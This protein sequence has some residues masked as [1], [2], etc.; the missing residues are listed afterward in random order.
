MTTENRDKTKKKTWQRRIEKA[1][2]AHRP[3][4]KDWSIGG[5]ATFKSKE[6]ETFISNK[7]S[8][9]VINIKSID[10]ITPS[11]NSNIIYRI[12]TKHLSVTNFIT[13]FEMNK[14]PLII[15]KIPKY[16]HWKAIKNWNLQSL[17]SHYK[18]CLFKV[19]EDDD[20]YKLK[21]KLKYFLKYLRHN[22]DDSP[23]YIFDSNYDNNSISK[24]LLDDY[25]V[26]SYFPDDLFSLVG[27]KRRPPY[28]SVSI[29]HRI[30]TLAI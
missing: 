12:N 2:K 23:L 28:R 6:N 5:F 19:G 14:I 10:H 26:P 29:L 21:V 8:E 22:T 17:K 20:G 18:N 9:Q 1:K 30:F 11:S 25:Q 24:Q 4:L 27:E 15:T 7:L 16:E 13:T 3:K